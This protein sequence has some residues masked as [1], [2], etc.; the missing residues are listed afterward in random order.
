MPDYRIVVDG[1]S[2]LQFRAFDQSPDWTH[3][4]PPRAAGFISV[5][6]MHVEPAL[7]GLPGY[8]FEVGLKIHRGQPPTELGHSSELTQTCH[9]LSVR[10]FAKRLVRLAKLVR[11][12]VLVGEIV[13]APGVERSD[14]LDAVFTANLAAFAAQSPQL[15]ER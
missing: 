1:H 3:Q 12:G 14:L 6:K 5:R 7:G 10:V 2:G 9:Q 11:R 4:R 8:A 13:C 15:A